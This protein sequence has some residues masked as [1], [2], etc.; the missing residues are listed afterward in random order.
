M[1]WLGLIIGLLVL[2]A[3]AGAAYQT[4]EADNDVEKYP[5]P[6][7]MI[8]AGG[9]RL[10]VYCNGEKAASDDPTVV[11]ESG[12]GATST[13][14]RLVQPEVARFARVCSYDRAGLGWSEPGQQPRT[15]QQC[16]SELRSLLSNAGIKPP[17]ILVGH[18][19][20]GFPLRLFVDRYPEEV[21]GL[22]L[23]DPIHPNEWT[24]MT[25]KQERTLRFG[26]RICRRGGRLARLGVA[27]LYLNLVIAG[28]L[29]IA[30]PAFH[31]L[32][33]GAWTVGNRVVN[34]LSKLPRELQPVILAHWSAPKFFLAT[35]GHMEH[36]V[37]SAHE[38]AK[39]AIP[40]EIPVTVLTPADAKPER[41]YASELLAHESRR[42]RHAVVEDAG[43]FIQLDQPAAVVSA[44]REIMEIVSGD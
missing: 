27:R 21:A 28:R 39:T 5:P 24:E 30:R 13:S 23:I 34:S 22:V 10:H 29:G 31:F 15:A 14:W 38:V 32:S 2:L 11:F 33:S 36:L 1:L 35:A 4:I 3:A 12:L 6:G 19:Y 44:V 7:R 40:P 16:V 8:D 18:S 37:G 25:P 41:K 43:H 20:A 9:H 26:I 17:Y 42:G